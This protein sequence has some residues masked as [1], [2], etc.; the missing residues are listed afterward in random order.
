MDFDNNLRWV[1]LA[2]GV[3]SS[4]VRMKFVGNLI[5]LVGISL[6]QVQNS[7]CSHFRGGT[8]T[9]KPANPSDPANTKVGFRNANAF[10]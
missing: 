2:F 4:C 7:V 8:F 10:V 9:Y 6:V 3:F 5:L 1:L